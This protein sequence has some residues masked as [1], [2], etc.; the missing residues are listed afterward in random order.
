M[1]P[2]NGNSLRDEA[3]KWLTL[4]R[5]GVAM[6]SCFPTKREG[7][8][9]KCRKNRKN[10]PSITAKRIGRI[11]IPRDSALSTQHSSL[12][13]QSVGFKPKQTQAWL[14]A[15]L[16]PVQRKVTQP[17][18]R[19]RFLATLCPP[20]IKAPCHPQTVAMNTTAAARTSMIILAKSVN[21]PATYID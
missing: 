10:P 19:P 8:L 6:E 11:P 7:A 1:K 13:G 2:T 12:Q 9:N 18:P 3:Y 14:R 15:P 5:Q 16:L 4:V 21:W 20:Q 17:R